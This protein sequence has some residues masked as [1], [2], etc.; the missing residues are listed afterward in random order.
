MDDGFDYCVTAGS[1]V[2]S[3]WV[4]YADG[5]QPH[6]VVTVSGVA[7]FI[8]VDPITQQLLP[9]VLDIAL[10]PPTCYVE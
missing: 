6:W 1:P 5:F 8:H 4:R 2:F 3:M 10:D 7:L 9:H